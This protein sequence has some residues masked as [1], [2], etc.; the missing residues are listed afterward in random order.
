M[1][2]R[3]ACRRPPWSV[4]AGLW[5]EW[6]DPA[7]GEVVPSYTMVTVSADAHPMMKRMRKPDPRLGADKAGQAQPGAA[8]TLPILDQWLSGTVEDAQALIKLTPVELSSTSRRR[9]RMGSRKRA[10]MPVRPDQQA[11]RPIYI[12]WGSVTHRVAQAKKS[13]P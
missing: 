7:T 13:P 1:L 2:W 11:G 8:R 9:T 5:S 10:R 3:F 6:T 12:R 4:L